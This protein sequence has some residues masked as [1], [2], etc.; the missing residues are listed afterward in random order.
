METRLC[1]FC[2]DII[3]IT[4]RRDSLYCSDDCYYLQ[5][6]SR[7]VANNKVRREKIELVKNDEILHQLY[8]LYQSNFYI[9]ATEL[10]SRDFKWHI[11]SG[12]CQV[13]GIDAQKMIRYSYTLFINQSIIIWKL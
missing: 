6:K 7:E 12:S 1:R 8:A 5:K 13:S 4:R 2:E 10:I 3:P 9:S 11:Y